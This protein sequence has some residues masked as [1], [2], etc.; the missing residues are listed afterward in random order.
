MATAK[1]RALDRLRQEALHLRRQQELGA[2]ADARGDH[3]VPDFSDA[4]DDARRHRRRPA[5]PDLHRLPP[6]AVAP[7]R[8]S[9]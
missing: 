3:V 4:L 7:K 9:R 8:A 6:G 1:N 5:A 2:D